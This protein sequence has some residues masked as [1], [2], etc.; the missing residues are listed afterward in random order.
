MHFGSREEMARWTPLQNRVLWEH[1]FL[2]S[3][4]TP[5]CAPP[6]LFWDPKTYPNRRPSDRAIERPSD[7]ASDRAVERST[8]RSSDRNQMVITGAPEAHLTRWLVR[9]AAVFKTNRFNTLP[10]LYFIQNKPERKKIQT[11]PY[12]F[13]YFQQLK[14]DSDA[15]G[16][17][18]R[19]DWGGEPDAKR[20][21][22]IRFKSISYKHKIYST[23]QNCRSSSS[24]PYFGLLSI[25]LDIKKISPIQRTPRN[26]P[27]TFTWIQNV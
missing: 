2:V 19:P 27:K 22:I 18:P 7:R 17:F 8:D 21:Q 11:L 4:K 14:M 12:C 15:L 13:W 6:H 5:K 25:P 3:I 16:G 9:C 23:P 20:N 26:S 24:R 1:R 10:M